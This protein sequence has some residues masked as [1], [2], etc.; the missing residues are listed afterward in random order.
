M[1]LYY[2][3][4]HV[5]FIIIIVLYIMNERL[6]PPLNKKRFISQ[7]WLWKKSQNWEFI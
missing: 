3:V 5:N 1:H 6:F 4:P 7:F 2:V